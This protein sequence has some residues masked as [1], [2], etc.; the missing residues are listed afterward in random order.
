MGDSPDGWVPQ[1][2]PKDSSGTMTMGRLERYCRGVCRWVGA[3]I[4]I[5]VA[6]CSG[7]RAVDYTFGHVIEADQHWQ[8]AV[9]GFRYPTGWRVTFDGARDR[10]TVRLRREEPSDRNANPAIYVDYYQSNQTPEQE[11]RDRERLVLN[12]AFRKP[13]GVQHWRTTIGGS[14]ARMISYTWT[15][16]SENPSFTATEVHQVIAFVR[17]DSLMVRITYYVDAEEASRYRPDFEAVL[18]TFEFK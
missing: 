10:G 13:P 3:A 9:L 7:C 16:H 1:R 12:E 18:S 8:C 4:A 6:S 14:P 15:P 5:L 11:A 2:Y 17:Q